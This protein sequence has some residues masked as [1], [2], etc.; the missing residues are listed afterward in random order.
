M[1]MVVAYVERDRVDPIREEL[2][3]L[4]FLSLSILDASGS[5]PEPVVSGQYRGVEIEQHTRPK[6]RLECVAGDDQA[7]IA[8][9]SILAH[10]GERTFAFA[11]PVEQVSQSDTVKADEAPVQAGSAP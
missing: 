6:A 8:L 10:G 9:E 2:L 4:G 11:V 3:K 5:F 7:S 1:K